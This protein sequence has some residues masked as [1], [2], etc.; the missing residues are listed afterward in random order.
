MIKKERDK[1]K[2]SRR[3]S[4]NVWPNLSGDLNIYVFPTPNF[5]VSKKTLVVDKLLLDQS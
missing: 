4:I 1:K 3:F 5:E 2:S